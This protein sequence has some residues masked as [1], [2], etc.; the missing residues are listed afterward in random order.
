MHFVTDEG[1][2]SVLRYEDVSFLLLYFLLIINNYWMIVTSS[3]SHS[4]IGG[5][6]NKWRRFE[7]AKLHWE[8]QIPT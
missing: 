6:A 2:S 3:S 4:L 7:N 8:L 1:F 5:R